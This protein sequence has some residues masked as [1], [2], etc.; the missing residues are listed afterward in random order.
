M[1]SVVIFGLT[2]ANCRIP[3]LC[4]PENMEREPLCIFL[5]EF[6]VLPV[7]VNYYIKL[8]TNHR[9]YFFSVFLKSAV[10]SA[11]TCICSCS[12]IDIN[13]WKGVRQ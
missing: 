5:V 4:F 11:G 8:A 1:T 12:I 9:A 10:S 7:D 3:K 13:V 6:C 2:S